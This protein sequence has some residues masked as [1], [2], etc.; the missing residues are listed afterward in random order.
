MLTRILIL[1][2]NRDVVVNWNS[3][4]PYGMLEFYEW[5]KTDEVEIIN[6]V[7]LYITSDFFDHVISEG[8]FPDDVLEVIEDCTFDGNE[9]LITYMD[10]VMLTDGNRTVVAGIESGFK[11][12]TR[13]STVTPRLERY[14]ISNW[15]L[16]Y[17]EPCKIEFTPKKILTDQSVLSKISD[18]KYEEHM[19]GLTRKEK[20]LKVILLDSFFSLACTENREELIYWYT[21]IYEQGFDSQHLSEMDNDALVESMLEFVKN[22]WTDKHFRLGEEL[23][24]RDR[25]FFGAWHEVSKE[26]ESL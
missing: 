26:L 6:T 10:T 17:G 12:A 19:V 3:K 24:K 4:K 18:L 11:Y 14:F 23:V 20:D 1:N 2:I 13:L 5:R 8:D 7:G 9:E 21:E 16:K 25:S 22:G 15:N